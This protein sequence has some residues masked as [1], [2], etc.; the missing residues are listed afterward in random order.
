MEGV[1]LGTVNHSRLMANE[2]F[3][4]VFKGIDHDS[5]RVA[6]FDLENGVAIS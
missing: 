4:A 5:S 2:H 1:E 6:K 3:A